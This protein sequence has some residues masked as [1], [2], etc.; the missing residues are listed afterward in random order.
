MSPS[1]VGGI[2]RFQTLVSLSLLWKTSICLS[3][4]YVMIDSQDQIR[5]TGLTQELKILSFFAS[6]IHLL[7]HRRLSFCIAVRASISL[8]LM[9]LV[10]SR[11]LPRYLQCFQLLV[12]FKDI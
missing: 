12:L 10:V 5:K 1:L 7:S 11:R 3:T 2:T 4:V 9:L 8:L 6:G